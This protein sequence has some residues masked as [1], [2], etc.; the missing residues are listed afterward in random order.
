M[1]HPG[2][3]GRNRETNKRN[4]HK[5]PELRIGATISNSTAS[6]S[7][8]RRKGTTATLL[9]EGEAQ[10]PEDKLSPFLH[11]LDRACFEQFFGL[12]HIRLRAGG[13]E[14]NASGSM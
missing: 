13:E 6:F 3:L 7:F 12:D 4:Y 11:G 1:A 2:S 14:L 9:S 10:I 5:G 8:R